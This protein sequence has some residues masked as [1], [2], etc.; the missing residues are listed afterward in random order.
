M[1]PRLR[2]TD[3]QIENMKNEFLKLDVDGDGTITVD[4]LANVLRAL[5]PHLDVTEDDIRRALNDIDRN[6]DGI[7]NVE[8]YFK[9]RKYKT[10]M[11]LLHRALV[12]RSTIRKE[13][14]DFDQDQNGYVTQDELISV[15]QIRVGITFT[16]EQTEK[17]IQETDCDADGRINYEEFVFLMTR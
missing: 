16:K 5:S 17:I 10:N 1:T 4:E 3:S 12:L 6:G 14:E 15:I 7:V 9:S 11:D 8:E 13:F 2:L